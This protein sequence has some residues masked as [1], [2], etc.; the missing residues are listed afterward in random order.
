MLNFLESLKGLRNYTY[1]WV[2][3]YLRNEFGLHTMDYWGFILFFLLFL[4]LLHFNQ[5]HVCKAI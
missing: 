3:V 5:S 4:I 2:K 1:V